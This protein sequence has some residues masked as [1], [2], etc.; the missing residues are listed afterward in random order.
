[1]ESSEEYIEM[2]S[3]SSSDVDELIDALNE[4]ITDLE[5]KVEYYRNKANEHFR[6]IEQLKIRVDNLRCV[7]SS[8]LPS[9]LDIL[10]KHFKII[11][12]VVYKIGYHSTNDHSRVYYFDGRQSG[13]NIRTTRP[14]TYS[15]G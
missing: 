5:Q 9:Y 10:E 15:Y 14:N 13:T 6:T 7:I 3:E 2:F 8:N 4:E 12:K 11:P 1:M